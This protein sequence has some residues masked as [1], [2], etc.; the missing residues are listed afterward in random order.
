MSDGFSVS[1]QGLVLQHG[2]I[3]FCADFEVEFDLV[4]PKADIYDHKGEC[5]ADSGQD[6]VN[7]RQVW[8]KSVLR[9]KGG[10]PWEGCSPSEF[11]LVNELI[12]DFCR[13]TPEMHIEAFKAAKNHK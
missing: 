8:V 11:S 1:I 9:R 12:L 3:E 5:L 13:D 7:F 2:P 10:G 4:N 6:E